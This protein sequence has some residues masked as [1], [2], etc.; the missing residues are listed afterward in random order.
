MR[1]RRGWLCGLTLLVSLSGCGAA[2]GGSDAAATTTATAVASATTAGSTTPGPTGPAVTSTTATS[3]GPTGAAAAGSISLAQP[4]TALTAGLRVSTVIGGGA[5]V[6]MTVDTGSNGV[7]VSRSFV[8]AAAT[9]LS[10]ARTFTGFSYSSSG[11]TYS[12]EWMT[13]TLELGAP[14]GS[15]HPALT[16]PMLIRVVDE[17]DV[18]M[19]GVGFDRSGSEPDQDLDGPALNPFLNLTAMSTGA[20]PQAYVVGLDAIVLGPTAGDL[21]GFQTVALTKAAGGKD[22]AAPAA[23]VTVPSGGVTAQ[24]GTLLLDTGLGYAIVQVPAGVE[25]PTVPAATSGDRPSVAAGQQVQITVAGLSAPLY[26]FTVGA[27]GA[28]TAVQ[29]GHDLSD[30][31]PFMNISRYA[32]TQHDYLYD[33][34]SG[35]VGFRPVG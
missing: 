3:A 32:L 29:W 13:A 4:S 2:A 16:V 19:M 9:P 25:P 18:A 30:G 7:L 12:G 26:D 34:T 11:N 22:W 10:P 23:C 24:C 33:A 31:Q 28:P 8:G 21:A 5:P 6:D 20:M 1:A 17:A 27:T 14:G 35:Q 15:G